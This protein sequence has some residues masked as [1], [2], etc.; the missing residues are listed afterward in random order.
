MAG[1]ALV[2]LEYEVAAVPRGG[3]AAL[4]TKLM[5]FISGNCVGDVAFIESM[6]VAGETP[7]ETRLLPD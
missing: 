5:P 3:L 1:G 4:V 2:L 6:E 7:S